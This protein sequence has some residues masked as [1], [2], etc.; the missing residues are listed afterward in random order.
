MI[1]N[2]KTPDIVILYTTVCVV[3][4][5]LLVW[6]LTPGT[7]TAGSC[8]D[9]QWHSPSSPCAPAATAHSAQYNS[10][11]R[12]IQKSFFA[13]S[14]LSTPNKPSAA[15]AMV[16]SPVPKPFD[17]ATL[18][19]SGLEKL[20]MPLNINYNTGFQS[21][22]IDI[23]LY[24]H[25]LRQVITISAILDSGSNFILVPTNL[26]Q[27]KTCT[28][29]FGLWNGSGNCFVKNNIDPMPVLSYGSG[30]VHTRVWRTPMVVNNRGILVDFK[31]IIKVSNV[32]MRYF[33]AL[34][35]LLPTYPQL[36]DD[37]SFVDQVLGSLSKCVR[38]F[39]LDLTAGL[40]AITFGEI[41]TIGK[42]VSLL[43]DSDYIDAQV[44]VYDRRP[45]LFYAVKLVRVLVN[46][47][48]CGGGNS[49]FAT[50]KY[51]ILDTGT[52]GMLV[53]IDSSIGDVNTDFVNCINV[54]ATI[55]FVLENDARLTIVH[56]K[57][58]NDIQG[59]ATGLLDSI[60]IGLPALVNTVTS[61]D[62]DGRCL[63]FNS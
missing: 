46:G 49:S 2:I 12:T 60:L 55:V 52:S 38:G 62:L 36:G 24:D 5:V 7:R 26:C 15:R 31:G 43:S 44:N 20:R 51:A 16:S 28:D 18:D 57:T 21:L 3:T 45:I 19:S 39:V 8:T 33:P 29:I 13:N 61:Y 14:G 30:K 56:K 59:G 42:R 11:T 25:N 35:G 48:E 32:A 22:G 23:P 37:V 63:Y 27:D 6:Y 40:E 10:A 41:N 4:I 34:C 47:V 58:S 53:G 1:E 17:I 54:D 9:W 50:P